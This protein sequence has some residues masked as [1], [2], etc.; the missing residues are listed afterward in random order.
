MNKQRI[1]QMIDNARTLDELH[2]VWGVIKSENL[3]DDEWVMS[4]YDFKYN[5]IETI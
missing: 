4:W 1:K 3:H 5:L 2:S